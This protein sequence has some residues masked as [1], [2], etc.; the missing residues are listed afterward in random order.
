MVGLPNQ[1]LISI[2][3][4]YVRIPYPGGMPGETPSVARSPAARAVRG[5]C[6]KATIRGKVT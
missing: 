5:N 1:M 2:L 4:M 6:R 3:E